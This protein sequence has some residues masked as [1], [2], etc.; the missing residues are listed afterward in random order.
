MDH[1]SLLAAFTLPVAN[2]APAN[3]VFANLISLMLSTPGQIPP[4]TASPNS[5]TPAGSQA[6]AASPAEIADAMI[7]SMLGRSST[8]APVAIPNPLIVPKTAVPQAPVIT[9]DPVVA[10]STPDDAPV[11]IPLTAVNANPAAPGTTN[12]NQAAQAP[13]K[14]PRNVSDTLMATVTPVV[15]MP[16]LPT[17]VTPPPTDPKSNAPAPAMSLPATTPD[18]TAS[19][20]T[21]PLA[22]NSVEAKIA[23]TAI[24]T[25]TKDAPEPTAG[26]AAPTPQPAGAGN[27][28]TPVALTTVPQSATA[29]NPQPQGATASQAVAA[30]AGGNTQPDGD[31]SAQQEN[32][33]P[34]TPARPAVLAT[35]AKIKPDVQPDDNALQ[36]AAAPGVGHAVAV[37]SFASSPTD[38]T[39]T[40][41]PAQSDATSPAATPYNATA[42]ALRTTESNLAAA[43][44]LRTGAAQEISIRIAPPDS[45]AVD[46]RVVERDGQV[47]VD[48]RT[49]DATMQTSLRQDLGTLS[50]SLERAG[51]HTETF[52]PASTLGRTASSAQTGN[53]DNQQDPSQNRGG[54]GDFSDGR[55]QQQ[56][57]RSGTWL[58]ELEEQS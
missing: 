9:P 6:S 15:T 44:P 37:P 8:P 48:V 40:S 13:R 45:P 14:Q 47:H 52:T 20:V 55:R 11:Q 49:A 34:E 17:A 35:A 25:P 51:Y 22:K 57:K 27:S 43:P 2:A 19:V 36:A 56:Q 12:P 28:S 10:A 50:S 53:Q 39:R 58:E 16:A 18:S 21:L 42:E 23:F 7:R 4:S 33:S 30:Q 54:Q 29:A 46:L 32:D 3:P 41:A 26:P 38:P 31:A 24:L 1:A 5:K